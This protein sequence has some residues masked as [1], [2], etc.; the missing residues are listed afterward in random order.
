MKTLTILL[1]AISF[2]ITAAGASAQETLASAQDTQ[3]SVAD[4]GDK[5]WSTG[6]TGPS[7]SS[8]VLTCTAVQSILVA[9][10]K[11][12]LFQIKVSQRTRHSAPA[13]R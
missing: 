7:R 2:M 9:D 3:G 13:R 5:Y 8:D 6:C 12:L 4:P 11:Q 1:V 10:T